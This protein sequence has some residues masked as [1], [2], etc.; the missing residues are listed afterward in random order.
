MVFSS[1]VFL[2]IFFPFVWLV[3][4][5]VPQKLK[6]GFLL[7][8]SIAFYFYGE[9]Y[10]AS[11]M[12]LTIAVTYG[13]GCIISTRREW[14][15]KTAFFAITLNLGILAVFKYANFFTTQINHIFQNYGL[16][17]PVTSFHLPVGISFFTF[18]AVSCIVDVY[19]KPVK[20]KPSF[21]DTALYISFFP[22]LIAGPILRYNNFVPQLKN[23]MVHYR[24]FL[25]GLKR[26]IYGLAK[27]VLI[28][29]TLAATVDSIFALDF[30]QINASLCWTAGF[31]FVIQVYFDFSGYS[32]MAI[33]LGRM[34]GLKIPENFNYPLISRSVTEFW[35]RWHI[36]LSTWFKDYL[37][38]PMGGNRY[39]Q[40][41][42]YFNLWT[43]FVVCGLW[44]GAAWN[45]VVFGILHG[46]I[47]VIEKFFFRFRFKMPAA[48]SFTATFLFILLS[49]VVFR[50]TGFDQSYAFFEAMFLIKS[51]VVPVSDFIDSKVLISLAA[52]TV[53]IFPVYR[54]FEKI[55]KRT[56]IAL[57]AEILLLAFLFALS[58]S[59]SS[60]MFA[61]PF[62]YFRF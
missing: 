21:I 61:D 16:S 58:I 33:G 54:Y 24:S 57:Y 42:T 25:Y 29:N 62:I 56:V 35:R 53:F 7:F 8:S 27:K 60:M 15:F 52:G 23:R 59:H 20:E 13:A 5:V 2:Y 26:F 51:S 30:A 12:L 11:L 44:H 50:S 32:D 6:N 40:I 18:Q 14:A 36:S 49:F 39:G 43:V 22:Q 45:F 38:I 47:M 41:R 31:L 1:P 9:G 17:I 55:M 3:H 10:F 37:Y 34:F 4:S 46:C 48:I 28:A 19:R